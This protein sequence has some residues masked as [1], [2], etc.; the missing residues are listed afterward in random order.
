MRT[1]QYVGV[2]DPPAELQDAI[3]R[4]DVDAVA[5]LIEA[6][7]DVHY[8]DEDGYTASI[9]SAYCAWEQGDALCLL[10]LLIRCGVDLDAESSYTESALSVMSR[11][12]RFDGVRLLLGAGADPSPLEWTPLI[13]A[14]AIGSLD[15]VRRE[16]RTEVLEGTDRWSRTAWL[17]ALLVGDPEKA[18]LLIDR[19]ADQSARAGDGR[20]ALFFAVESDRTLFDGFW[21]SVTRSIRSTTRDTRPYTMSWGATTHRVSNF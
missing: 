14:V 1:K 5:L 13:G 6:G 10:E 9:H 15:D 7:A 19:G 4:C 12:G 20:Q 8:R 11:M 16:A 3:R 21:N 17:V 18:Q 2:E